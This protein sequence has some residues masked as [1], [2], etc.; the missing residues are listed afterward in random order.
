M[1]W[2]IYRLIYQRRKRIVQRF[3]N[4][5]VPWENVRR[6]YSYIHTKISSSITTLKK[7]EKIMTVPESQDIEFIFNYYTSYLQTWRKNMDF[8][9]FVNFDNKIN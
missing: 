4:S 8:I 2:L 7:K 6:K 3:A 5:S 1:E 9:S